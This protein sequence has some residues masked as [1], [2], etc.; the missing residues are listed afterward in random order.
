MLRLGGKGGDV[1]DQ[2][3]EYCEQAIRQGAEESPWS[4][5]IG[6]AV[7]GTERFVAGLAKGLGKG[8][9]GKRLGKRPTLDEVI[10]IL[11]GLK[12][13]KWERFRDRYGDSGRDLVLYLGR[14]VCGLSFRQLCDRVGIGY[15]SAA[16]AVWRF[17]ERV[18]KDAK[19]ARVL[20]QAM[21][22]IKNE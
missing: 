14:R 4:R 2:Y 21:N 13:E 9:M 6:Q 1:A 17:G 16:G 19:L 22:Q 8:E 10:K 18:E 3:R 5:T 20:R 11:A 7:L 15:S 12:G